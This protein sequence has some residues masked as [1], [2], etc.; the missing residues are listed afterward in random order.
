MEGTPGADFCTGKEM[1]VQANMLLSTM[2]YSTINNYSVP[3]TAPLWLHPCACA[4]CASWEAAC[5]WAQPR[6][7]APVQVPG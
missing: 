7:G 5:V 6:L 1:G 2:W 4:A 3:V